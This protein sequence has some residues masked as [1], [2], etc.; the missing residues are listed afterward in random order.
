MSYKA[1]NNFILRT[2]LL[3]FN[4]LENLLKDDTT[5]EELLKEVYKRKEIQE[6]VF[7]ASPNLHDKLLKWLLGDLNDKKEKDKI[8][9][10]LYKY[11]ARMSSRCTP[12]GLFAGISLGEISD[13][14]DIQLSDLKEYFRTTRLDMNYLCALA[15]NLSKNPKIRDAIK[16]YPN[17]S[18]YKTGD[19]LRYV[20]YK[21][22]KAQRTHHI[23][24]ID[25]SEYIQL[26][27]NT[28]KKGAQVDD[29]A[30]LLIDDEISF[31]DAKEFIIELIENQV[32][33]SELEPAV[34]GDNFLLQIIETIEN[35][36]G[37]QDIV[38]ILKDVY[39]KLNEIDNQSPGIDVQKY[40]Q[41]TETVEPLGTEYKINYMFQTD[42][43][44]TV[45][46]AIVGQD[47]IEDLKKGMTF[48]NK[49]TLSQPETNITKFRSAFYERYEDKA[50][51][52]LQALDTEIGIGYLQ[53][54][55]SGDVSP[56]VD[57]VVVQQNTTGLQTINWSWI[58]SFL[59]N[60][61]IKSVEENKYEITI[62]DKEISKYVNDVNWDDLPLTMSS[63]VHLYKAGDETKIYMSS[64]GGAGAANLLG[65]F[66]HTDKNIQE[67][68]KRITKKEEEIVNDKI[69]AEI[70]HLPE[71]RTGN[72]LLRPVLRDYEIPFLAKSAVGEEFQVS[73][74]D[75]M[76]FV[77]N[78]N[79][80][81]LYS[82][83]LKKEIIPRLSTAHN[84]SFNALPVYQ[85]FCDLQ[86][87]NLRGGL[88]FNWGPLANEFSFLPRVNYK[89]IIFS[90]AS[91]NIKKEDFDEIIKIKDENALLIKIK[92]W[93]NELNMPQWVALEDGDNELYLNLN[94]L[95]SIKTLI[96]LVKDR[97]S[98][99][100]T[101]VLTKQDDFFIKDT[102]SKEYYTNQFIFS[103][104]KDKE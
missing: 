89:N 78:Y 24:S 92:E 30:K 67:Y 20:E 87:Q 88:G 31:D 49:L 37:I 51:P 56:L 96:S 18:I 97:S 44:K 26:I 63:M 86:T 15:I 46:K 77:R 27:I 74:E 91:W 53:N 55:G 2:P 62:T 95:L 50:V 35:I 54:T 61:Y 102:E 60:K 33:V 99:K 29:L 72:I 6:A 19:A 104:Y 7:L 94:N 84:F 90:F 25:N 4:F 58:Y 80:I 75:L 82:K 41:I 70:I 100:L 79:E 73:L 22:F 52:L 8:K 71:S 34:T 3:S 103:F 69:F 5:D 65:R 45:R 85:F 43:N 38:A 48:L 83:K 23:V 14:T 9:Y 1:F 12:F 81:V 42:M 36:D 39:N 11:L 32:L 47:I 10:S 93:R 68:V 16:F 13:E 21:Y 101:E 57:D 76:I 17:T 64:A 40:Y 59:L 66:C 28:A 98:F